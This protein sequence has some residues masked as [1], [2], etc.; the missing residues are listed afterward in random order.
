ML[1]HGKRH[2]RLYMTYYRLK[3]K[4]YNS[5]NKDYPNYGGRGITICDEWLNDFMS[6]YDWA[7]NN[8]YRDDLTIDRIDVNGNYD[9]SNC[10][11]V[12]TKTQNRNKRTNLQYTINGETHCLGEWCEILNLDYMKVYQRIKRLHWTFEKAI[13][14]L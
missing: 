14:K 3:Q 8:N 12:D 5:N 10:R 7:I 13:T 2:T 1:K 11:W 6:F 4:C 9:P